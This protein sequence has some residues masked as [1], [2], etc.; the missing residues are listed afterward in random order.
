MNRRKWYLVLVIA[1]LVAL[2]AVSGCN[3]TTEVVKESELTI[4]TAPVQVQDLTKRVGYSGIVRGQNEV[5]LM[6]KAAARVTGIYVQPGDY[7]KAG[8]TLIT[9]DNTD[10]TC[11]S[12][13]RNPA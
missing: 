10:S 12:L 7:V 9:L 1:L 2:L 11:S 8:Q 4:N 6:P 3:K 5:Y 13:L